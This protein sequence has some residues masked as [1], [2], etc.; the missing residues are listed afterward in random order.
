[1]IAH[2]FANYRYSINDMVINVNG[3][4]EREKEYNNLCK[5]QSRAWGHRLGFEKTAID[6]KRHCDAQMK[7][8]LYIFA[9]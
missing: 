8:N 2:R 5:N 6:S 9:T 4:Q 7:K 3:L 1:M